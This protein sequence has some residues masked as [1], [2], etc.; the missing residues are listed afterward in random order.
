MAD[1]IVRLP[2]GVCIVRPTETVI[3]GSRLNYSLGIARETGGAARPHYHLAQDTL[4]H[5]LKGHAETRYGQHLSQSVVNGP[6]DFIYIGARVPHA[7]RNLS[8]TEESIAINARGDPA[9]QEPI[10]PVDPTV[11]LDVNWN[12]KSL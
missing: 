5:V 3:G 11:T 9:Q 6:G 4:I 2:L 8:D 7:P 1:P 10:V 12:E